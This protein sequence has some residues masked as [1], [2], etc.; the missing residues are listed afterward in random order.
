MEVLSF[1]IRI[2]VVVQIAGLV[3]VVGWLMIL[4]RDMRILIN[5]L[6]K[7]G[8]YLLSLQQSL[9]EDVTTICDKIEM[10]S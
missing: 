9:D 8:E 3:L 4:T 5:R 2:L 1:V 6:V 7:M 10:Q